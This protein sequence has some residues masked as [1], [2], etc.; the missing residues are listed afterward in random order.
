M[1]KFNH[2][3]Y[4]YS[5]LIEEIYSCNCIFD[6]FFFFLIEKEEENFVEIIE[7]KFKK[8]QLRKIVL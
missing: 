2:S 7:E 4:Y 5:S 3:I 6:Q 1:I 8:K